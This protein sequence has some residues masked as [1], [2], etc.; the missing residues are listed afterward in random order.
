MNIFKKIKAGA[1]Q[2]VLVISVII[3]IIIFAFIS[4]IYLQQ[5]LTIKHNFSKEAISNTIAVFDFI[6]IKEF[7]Y[8]KNSTIEVLENEHTNTTFQKK[9]WGIFD[10]GVATSTVK[11]E[12][13]QK[14]ALLGTQKKQRDALFLKDNN[15]SLVLVGKTK[16]VGNTSLP[17]QGVKTGNISGVSYYGNRL[18]Y[19]QQKQSS[20][21]LPKITN[22]ES[23]KTFSQQIQSN[24]YANFELEEGLKLHQSFAKEGLLYQDNN[25]IFLQNTRL[26]GQLLIVSKSKIIVS[27]SATLKNVILIAP[28]ITIESNTKGNFQAIAT[29]KILV[30]ENVHL[31]YPSALVVI[32]KDTHQIQSQRTNQVKELNSIKIHKNTVVKGVLVY[33]SDNIQS[34]F[35]AQIQI[36]ERV[37]IVGEVYSSKNIE[38]LGKVYGSVYTNNFII[39]KSGGVYVNHIYDGEIN[40]SKLP[41]Q[42][43]GL[44][45]DQSSNQ[46]AKWVD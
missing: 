32:H 42:Y 22:L 12:F 45:I 4:L 21:N 35:D 2:Y 5:R 10:I 40:I 25:S 16:I 38:L 13:F 14:V 43:T 7:P 18:I 1:L 20:S 41:E 3:A 28:V 17:K 33:Q 39:K 19:G 34:N 37:T 30:E 11:N 24:E 8:D 36:A 31:E 46:V 23:L 15:T 27:A 44:Q 6:K 26:T 29:K 9:H